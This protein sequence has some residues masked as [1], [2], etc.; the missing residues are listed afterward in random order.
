MR[1]FR[2]SFEKYERQISAGAI[3]L[4]FIIDSVTLVRIDE[5]LTELFLF[6]YLAVVAIGIVLINMREN[7]GL[8]WISEEAYLWLFVFVQFSF[9]G[10]FGRFFIYYSRSGSFATSWPLLIVFLSLLIG[11]EF[12]KKYYTRLLLQISFFFVALFAFLIFFIPILVNHVNVW[13]FLLSGAVSLLVMRGFLKVLTRLI[14]ERMK[15]SRLHIFL[16]VG[17]I[18]LAINIL[19][20]ANIIPPIPLAVREAGAYHSIVRTGSNY[21][22]GAEET[23][24]YNFF[25]TRTV[26][27]VSG[28]AVYL[29]SAIFAPT[30]FDT[31]IVHKWERYDDTQKKWLDVSQVTFPIIGGRGS[32]Y[33]GYSFKSNITPGLWRV[34]IETLRGQV[35]GRVKF[36]VEYVDQEPQLIT[37]TF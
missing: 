5:F 15:H 6:I 36:N 19:Y 28:E 24:W 37:K 27:I 13:V 30:N 14:P 7:G 26:H 29:Y 31:S 11:N 9:G 18:F 1:N 3:I 4:A 22:V 10:L 8:K 17:G 12:A 2:E 32:G 20:F 25:K 34:K 21:Q 35:M 16:A 23:K 33:R